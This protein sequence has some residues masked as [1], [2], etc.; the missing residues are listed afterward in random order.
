MRSDRRFDLVVI[1]LS[2]PAMNG[3]ELES[4]VRRLWPE[5]TLLFVTFHVDIEAL[6]SVAGTED[7]DAEQA[8]RQS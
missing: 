3:G 4:A 6:R 8:Q 7:L 1:D 2:M 5:A